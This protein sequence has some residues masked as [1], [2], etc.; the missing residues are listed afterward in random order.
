MM[1]HRVLWRVFGPDM[2]FPS[3]KRL[4][5]KAQ[6]R[7]WRMAD[8]QNLS[9]AQRMALPSQRRGSA[10]RKAPAKKQSPYAVAKQIPARNQATAK[11]AAAAAKKA[12]SP[13]QAYKQGK[14]GRMQ[15]SVTLPGAD[16]TLYR[17]VQAGRVVIQPGEPNRRRL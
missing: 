3:R 16:L 12:A 15:G 7:T 11:K 9:D 13:K 5:R 2:P 8:E 4:K 17:Q 6:G 14:D 10:P 1:P